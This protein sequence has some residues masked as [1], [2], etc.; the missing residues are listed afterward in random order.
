MTAD[1]ELAHALEGKGWNKPIRCID[2]VHSR[3]QQ[4]SALIAA[5]DAVCCGDQ[6]GPLHQENLGALHRAYLAV[7]MPIPDETP[8]CAS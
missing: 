3:G 6:F 1:Q 7:S 4:I 2:F 8:T 5:A